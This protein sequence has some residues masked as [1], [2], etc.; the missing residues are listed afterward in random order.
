[1]LHNLHF[2]FQLCHQVML[3]NLTSLLPSMDPL[4]KIAP[5]IFERG[6]MNRNIE[7]NVKDRCNV[8]W[9]LCI[10]GILTN[11]KNPYMNLR[12]CL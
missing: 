2:Q 7:E 8:F 10:E 11:K 5:Q 9:A 12:S 1:M 4:Q 6:S 3:S